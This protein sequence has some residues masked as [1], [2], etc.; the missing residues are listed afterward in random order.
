MKQQKN[1]MYTITLNVT[2][3]LPQMISNIR[4]VEEQLMNP[5]KV[6]RRHYGD[7]KNFHNSFSSSH[8]CE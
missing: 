6:E 8:I 7:V 2:D 3:D 5:L 4:G 1:S